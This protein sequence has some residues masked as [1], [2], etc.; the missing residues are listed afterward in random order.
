MKQYPNAPYWKII[1]T[2]SPIKQE[3][4]ASGHTSITQ[5]SQTQYHSITYAPEIIE[6]RPLKLQSTAYRC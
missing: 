1:S 5:I 2:L 6:K 3:K 4:D